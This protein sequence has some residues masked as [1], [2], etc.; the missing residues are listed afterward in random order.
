MS[1]YTQQYLHTLNT[2]YTQNGFLLNN[3]Y[4]HSRRDICAQV[5]K[6][7]HDQYPAGSMEEGEGGGREVPKEGEFSK[8]TMLKELDAL[9]KAMK[10][11]NMVKCVCVRECVYGSRFG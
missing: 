8:D 3:I 4:I 10:D 6:A 2:I 7:V 11:S 1:T 5:V 9:T